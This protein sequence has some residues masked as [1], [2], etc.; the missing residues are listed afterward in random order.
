MVSRGTTPLKRGLLAGALAA[1]L[2][3]AGLLSAGATHATPSR[4]DLASAKAR[5]EQLRND[6]EVAV[7]KY[8]TVHQRLVD[9]RKDIATTRLQVA[10]LRKS[11]SAHERKAR[12]FARQLYES[13]SSGALEMVLSS[14][15]LGEIESTLQYLK[16]TESTQ[17]RVFERLVVDKKKL[18]LK[19]DELAQARAQAAHD[20][21]RLA[22]LKSSIH[23]KMESQRHEIARLEEQI[24][25]AGRG[26]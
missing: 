12:L 23:S 19:L 25:R 1:A 22:E 20:V 13:G 16:R 8:D 15:S 26:R 24:R 6:F 18:S 7:E 2:V 21:A 5:L 9:I 11:I 14:K 17:A 3:A 10:D 4:S